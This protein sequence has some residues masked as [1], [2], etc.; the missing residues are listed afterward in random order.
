MSEYNN[1][2]NF[3]E[4]LKENYF[5][6]V[7]LAY[8]LLMIVCIIINSKGGA[9]NFA[10][11]FV[12]A[13]ICT[14][15]ISIYEVTSQRKILLAVEFVAVLIGML[16]CGG[17]FIVLIP[18][19][20]SDA[21]SEFNLP[22]YLWLSP[23]ALIGLT[24]N[25][26]TYIVMCV[27]TAII[28]YQHYEMITKYCR[29]AENYEQQE[30]KLKDYIDVN[31]QEF[32][33][34]IL[35]TNLHYENMMLQNKVRLVQELHDKL[36]HRINGSIYQLEACKALSSSNPEKTDEILT[37]VTDEL[38]MGMDEIRV[39]LRS[40]RPDSKRMAV[41]QLMSL[42]EDCRRKYGIEAE[43]NISKN[44]ERINE[45]MWSLILDNCCEAVTNALKYSKCSKINIEINVLNKLLRCCI[46]D[47]G[48]GC[49]NISEGI[50]L[51]G[52]KRRVS[53]FGG[54][55]DISG[56]DGFKI[57]MLIPIN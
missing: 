42:C 5:A 57:N 50:G 12:M 29:S 9:D 8:T 51:Q 35:R 48:I 52:M 7:K 26:F 15:V 3:G 47:N 41:L 24:E 25:K 4:L 55:I 6:G 39:M 36:G 2:K 22:V 37:R 40:E 54:A 23:I 56:N 16:F 17:E 1:K 18:V 11:N 44:S 14:S 21:V 13:A 19:I 34:E 38:R 46:S 10:L 53:N 30:L 33:S 43:L 27:L 32:K 49:Q 20:I 28:Y 45:Q 31:T